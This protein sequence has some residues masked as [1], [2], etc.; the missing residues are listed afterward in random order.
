MKFTKDQGIIHAHRWWKDGDLSAVE[1]YPTGNPQAVDPLCGQPLENHGEVDSKRL[2]PGN[3]VLETADGYE[4]M[5]DE[6]LATT[7]LISEDGDTQVVANYDGTT[8]E[9]KV[10]F[11]ADCRSHTQRRKFDN[12]EERDTYAESHD[13]AHVVD[14]YEVE[15]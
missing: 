13:P 1:P 2:C 10:D 3:W 11:Y 4:I 8:S 9:V 7:R 6:P 12:R 5:A 15:R 14:C